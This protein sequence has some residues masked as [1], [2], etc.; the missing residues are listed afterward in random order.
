METMYEIQWTF[1]K[2]DKLTNVNIHPITV[3]TYCIKNGSPYS[4]TALNSEGR[5]ISGKITDYFTSEAD[6]ILSAK[7]DIARR[8]E[9]IAIEKI[10]LENEKTN[11]ENLF[12]NLGV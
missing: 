7:N 2:Q 1:N 8:L 12:R 3:L 10:S 4:I 11:L 5:K 6:A 9:T